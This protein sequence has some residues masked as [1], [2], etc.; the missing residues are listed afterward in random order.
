MVCRCGLGG[1]EEANLWKGTLGKDTEVADEEDQY[2]LSIGIAIREVKQSLGLGWMLTS[3]DKF[4]RKHHL[5][6]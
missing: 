2:Q 5:Q 4:S 1:G 6:R 3:T